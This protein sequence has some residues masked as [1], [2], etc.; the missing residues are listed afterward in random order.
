MSFKQIGFNYEL[1]SPRSKKIVVDVDE[2]ELKKDTLK[3]DLPV[4]ADLAAFFEQMEGF[5]YEKDISEWT[6]YCDELKERFPIYQEK[7]AQN[8]RVNPY[9]FAHELWKHLG[10]D[11]IVILGN[12][13]ACVCVGQM[14]IGKPG[15]RLYANKNCGTMG[16]DIPAALGAAIAKKGEV[17]CVTGDGSFQMNIQELQTIVQDKLPVK[18]I[19]FNNGGYQAIMQ[20]QE[21]FF[22]RLSGCSPNSGLSLPKLE[23][24]AHAYEIS[25]IRIE[26]ND[27]LQEG[28]CELF[29]HQGYAICELMQ[30]VEQGIEPRSKSIE[31]KSGQIVS[32]PLDHL[33]PFLPEE[34][35]EAWEFGHYISQGKAG[36]VR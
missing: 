18:M 15:Q 25:Y 19:V 20:T 13:V 12:S 3:I 6:G 1:F 11:G 29:S 5:T 27:E 23:R 28:L 24:I 36:A 35:Y 14:G 16:Y 4:H 2:E 31:K 8:G 33:F 34:E 10:E 30:D 9:Q 17:V 26:R 21:N 32:P 22:G 7:F